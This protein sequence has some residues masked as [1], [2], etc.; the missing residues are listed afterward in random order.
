MGRH[1]KL[2]TAA[3]TANRIAMGSTNGRY[4]DTVADYHL[5]SRM[6]L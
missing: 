6:M 4:V 5:T 3:D 2:F 1:L